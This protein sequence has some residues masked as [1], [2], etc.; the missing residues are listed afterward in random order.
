[1]WGGHTA[2]AVLVSSE[3][4]VPLTN[5]VEYI[6]ISQIYC[7]TMQSASNVRRFFCYGD[8]VLI[9]RSSPNFISK[10]F[11][12][13]S[14][15]ILDSSMVEGEL[16]IIEK[17]ETGK[18]FVRM[19]GELEHKQINP[20]DIIKRVGSNE[21]EIF[22]KQLQTKKRKRPPLI[23]SLSTFIIV[24]SAFF[25]LLNIILPSDYLSYKITIPEGLYWSLW[26]VMVFGIIKNIYNYFIFSKMDDRFE[27]DL[28]ILEREYKKQ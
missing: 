12:S 25:G 5:F 11:K 16:G 6:N 26:I 27:K 23:T 1:M 2:R 20:D 10:I 19:I 9:K 13:K 18:L 4:I 17:A 14:E 22:N 28:W 7:S 24:T 15:S 21:F 3:V 8:L